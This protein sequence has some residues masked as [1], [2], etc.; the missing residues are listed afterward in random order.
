VTALRTSLAGLALVLLASC[1]G[2]VN[3]SG[4]SADVPTG[5]GL[6]SGGG[7]SSSATT[8]PGGTDPPLD[9]SKTQ[10]AFSA[11]RRLTREQYD[12]SIRDLLG[13]E[14]HPSLAL[15]AD[16][17]LAAFF[18]NSVSP[19]SRLSVE[20]YRDSAE[21]LA[22][23][24]VKQA[25][26]KLAG[27]TGANQNAA[28][29]DQFIQSFGRRAFR[30]PLSAEEAARYRGL[31]DANQARGFGEGIRVVLLAMLQSPN[32]VYHL[33]LTP[34]P[35]GMAVTPLGGYEVASRLSYAL[36]NTLPD[37]E[38]L[39]AASAGTLDSKEG[40]R[41][42]AERL[43][44]SDRA[45]DALSSFHVQW[46]GLDGL[47]D[48]DKDPQLFPQFTDQLKSAMQNEAV[49]FADFVIRRGDG[50]LQTL[51]SAPFTV[52]SPDL[53]SLYGA[54][55]AAAADGTVQL[56]PTQR[57]GLLT[58]AGFLSAH[59]HANQTSPVHRGL[60]VRKNLL[61]T[62]LP[63][64]PANVNNNPP[65]PDPNAT[66]RQRF[67]QHRTDPSCAGCHQMMD[68]IGI[69]FEN[70]DA[71]GRYRTTENNLPVD[72]SGEVVSGGETSG[73]FTGAVELAKR[74][75]TSPEVRAC[76]Q[77]QW[78]RFS[79]GRFEGPEDA[80]TLA[81]LNADFAASDFDVK[82]LL[83]SLV[84]SDAFRYRKVEP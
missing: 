20:Q 37:T 31:F 13:I 66:T 24:A 30:R 47:L 7:G 25:L 52:A 59:A 34:A 44:Q 54:T 32:F 14:G 35:S 82:K 26:D 73:T 70:Y 72:A 40:L 6:T 29:A 16:E 53:L 23:A 5:P 76:V 62:T 51:L 48:V 18:S 75:S 71:V 8:P 33:E 39:D 42:Q 43:L 21:D 3:G 77:K 27:C 79:L 11:L 28:C 60:A 10:V 45:K 80:C 65:E 22:A 49:N 41:A 36:W 58:Q 83:L 19:V 84:T 1:T 9:C 64:P 74:L 15:A 55:A 69:G 4:G 56:D 17:K 81:S 57:A 78:F 61:C 38:L 46:L 68:P 50:R 63:D 2:Q 67:E 12:N